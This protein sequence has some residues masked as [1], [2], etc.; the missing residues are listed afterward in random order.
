M[1]ILVLFGFFLWTSLIASAQQFLWTTA[2]QDSLAD[3]HVAMNDALDEILKFHDH[4][5]HHYDRSGFSKERFL[6]QLDYG[7]EDFEWINSINDLTIMALRS[8]SEGGSVVLVLFI[9]EKY[10]HLIVFSN[11]MLEGD[12]NYLLNYEFEKEKFKSWLHTLMN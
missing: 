9:S 6:E 4:Y 3:R 5:D 7:F 10:V 12:S 2:E 1:R 8:N 11:H